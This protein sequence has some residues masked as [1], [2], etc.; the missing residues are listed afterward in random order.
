MSGQDL[1]A[2]L[3]HCRTHADI[4]EIF[5]RLHFSTVPENQDSLQS[6]ELMEQEFTN[7]L[8]SQAFCNGTTQ[9]TEVSY[10]QRLEPT[11]AHTWI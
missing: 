4:T 8:L 1:N 3:S 5:R 2:N 7:L 9:V 10:G 11:G 6:N